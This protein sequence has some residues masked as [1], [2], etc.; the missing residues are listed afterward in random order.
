L[1]WLSGVGVAVNNGEQCARSA[2]AAVVLAGGRQMREVAMSMTPHWAQVRT[3]PQPFAWWA[4]MAPQ[5]SQTR[6]TSHT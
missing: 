1:R 4:G 2:S 3:R 6:Q 5:H